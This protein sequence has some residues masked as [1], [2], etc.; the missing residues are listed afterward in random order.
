M[1]N[2]SHFPSFTFLQ[3]PCNS[4][5]LHLPSTS[6]TCTVPVVPLNYCLSLHYMV[7]VSKCIILLDPISLNIKKL[8]KLWSFALYNSFHSPL[9]SSCVDPNIFLRTLLFILT[10]LTLILLTW[11]IWWAPNNAS[12]LQMGLNSVFKGLKIWI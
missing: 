7:Y 9:T 3:N 10:Q 1:P 5:C 8:Q 2:L 6:A 4:V 11:R 12:K